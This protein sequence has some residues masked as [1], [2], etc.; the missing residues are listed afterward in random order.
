MANHVSHAGLPYPVKGARFTLAVPYL[1]ADGDPT[2]PTTPD[3]EISKDGAAFTDCTEEVTT[4]T[5]GN[6]SGYI[7]LTGDETNCSLLVVCAKVAS[8]P[9]ATLLHV[10][11]RVL[12]SIATG[13][14]QGG[15]A[16]SITLAAG[17]PDWDLTGCIVQ[18]TGGT[19]GGGGSGSANNQA[20][21]IV[22]YD[23][24]TK[25]AT[26]SPNWEVTPDGTTTYKVLLT[27]FS[28]ALK[29]QSNQSVNASTL[30]GQSV[31]AAGAVT[32]G[33]Y[34][35]NN[36]ALEAVDGTGRAVAVL[37]DGVTHGGTDA[38]LALKKIRVLANDQDGAIDVDNTNGTCIALRSGGLPGP[39]GLGVLDIDNTD[40]P[41][42]AV[43]L[44]GST[45]Q[46]ALSCSGKPGMMLHAQGG[47]QSMLAD[48]PLVGT[49][50]GDLTGKV[51][52]GG[53]STI[54]GV[55]VQAS[56]ASEYDAA[57][58]AA[59]QSSV[60]ALST[61]LNALAG[62][63]TG[64]TSLAKWLRAMA[65]KDTADST[66]RGEINSGGGTFDEST[67]SLEAIADAPAA[68][69]NI[70]TEETVVN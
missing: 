63:F 36:T 38:T 2:D 1:D 50:D 14:A 61:G 41:A 24:A 10:S 29:L 70:V 57:K 47:G 66:A 62:V 52:G 64:I 54:G 18:T 4:I 33:A 53:G 11:P 28:V 43:F 32:V 30:G 42:P 35:G 51:L 65:R 7:T 68:G 20:R 37:A 58:T 67:D 25:V 59:S 55:G 15:A 16:S 21:L 9:K 45:A 8:G 49:L 69:V 12:P 5:G 56:L 46:P 22:A 34:V 39:L 60:N 27:E 26:V 23:T 31:I 17:A 48:G 40:Y 44:G 3:T 19:G 6:G 13:T